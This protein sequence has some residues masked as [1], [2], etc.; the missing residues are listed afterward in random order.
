VAVA[1]RVLARIDGDH[2]GV[3]STNEAAAYAELGEKP[4]YRRAGLSQSR[5]E[6]HR[7]EFLNVPLRCTE[8]NL[9]TTTNG[10]EHRKL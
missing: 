7:A 4:P 8:Y 1:E 6:L 9:A 2:D 10:E 3:I 5:I